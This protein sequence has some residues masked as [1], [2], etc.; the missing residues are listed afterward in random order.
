[1]LCL[2]ND[3]RKEVFFFFFFLQ[4]VCDF[5]QKAKNHERLGSK[6][7]GLWCMRKKQLNYYGHDEENHSFSLGL[8]TKR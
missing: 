4:H 7:A 5:L 1:V 2:K 8:G 6:R 3:E